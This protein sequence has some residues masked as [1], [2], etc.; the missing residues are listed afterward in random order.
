MPLTVLP[1]AL[2]PRD[3]AALFKHIASFLT[4]PRLLHMRAPHVGR[5]PRTFDLDFLGGHVIE[6]LFLEAVKVWVGIVRPDSV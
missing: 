4:H 6:V 5:K 2:P 3:V 1:L